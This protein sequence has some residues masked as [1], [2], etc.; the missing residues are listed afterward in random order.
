MKHLITSYLLASVIFLIIDVIWLSV[1]VKIFYKPQIGQLLNDKPIIWAAVL[2]YL[3]YTVGLTLIIIKPAI[4]NYD[5]FQAFWTGILF[6]IVAYGRDFI[7]DV[8]VS[9][10]IFYY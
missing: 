4:S 8:S 1:T 7:S 10:I 3:I 5:F 2:F 9:K 6:G